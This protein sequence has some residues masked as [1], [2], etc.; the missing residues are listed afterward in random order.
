VLKSASEEESG[1]DDIEYELSGSLADKIK[2][3]DIR[4]EYDLM[5]FN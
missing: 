2:Q 4:C 3:C 1:N 5:S